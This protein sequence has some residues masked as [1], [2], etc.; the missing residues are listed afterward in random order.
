VTNYYL[1]RSGH[2]EFFPY[3]D[4][5]DA[6]SVGWRSEAEKIVNG[7]SWRES[8]ERINNK[9][10]TGKPGNATGAIFCFAGRE[11]K[12]LPPMSE[13]DV[14][15][16]GGKRHIKGEPVLRAVAQVGEIAVREEPVS[17]DYQHTVYRDVKKWLYNDGP[18][19]RREL[20][21]VFQQGGEGST[22]FRGTLKQWKPDKK[23]NSGIE[24]LFNNLINGLND[25]PK[26]RP[27]QYDFEY[28]ER[29]V[30]EHIFDNPEKFSE[31]TGVEHQQLKREYRTEGHKRADFLALVGDEYAT[32]IE[33][34][35]DTAGPSAV[36]QLKGY[37]QEVAGDYEEHVQGVLVAEDFVAFEDISE[38][39]GDY[40]IEL[41]RYRVTLEY[42]DVV[43]E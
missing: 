36:R 2:K 4:E 25:A 14:V 7:A 19:A 21:D 26:I 41:K 20:D 18:V 23:N 13:D 37:M 15:I 38:E 16:V 9:Y 39:I 8:R 24:S 40:D 32:V 30:Q 34:K 6:V 1:L 31:G 33:I 29:V 12:R 35:S 27:K 11:G 43:L 10:S 17:E 22:R 3:W 42:D 28:D 5:E